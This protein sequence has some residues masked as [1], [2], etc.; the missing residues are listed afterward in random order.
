M[1]HNCIVASGGVAARN[2][3]SFSVGVL[4][5]V[6]TCRNVPVLMLSVLSDERLQASAICQ[7][8]MPGAGM[9]VC[10]IGCMQMHT[11]KRRHVRIFHVSLQLLLNQIAPSEST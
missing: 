8:T 2:F 10:G 9:R 5:H 11:R 1:L 6:S 4:L 7:R 3:C